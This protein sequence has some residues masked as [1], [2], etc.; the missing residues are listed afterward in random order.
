MRPLLDDILSQS[1]REQ[2]DKN[3]RLAVDKIG[4]FIRMFS[5]GEKKN[6][7]LESFAEYVRKAADS[8]Q[9]KCVYDL[10]DMAYHQCLL[11]VNHQ[12]ADVRGRY[13]ADKSALV[14]AKKRVDEIEN[15]LSVDIDD[16][17]VQKLYKTIA[18][19]N[20]QIEE[21]GIRI[22]NLKKTDPRQTVNSSEPL[23]SSIAV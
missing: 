4:E 17:K 16:K 21:I 5:K 15:Y 7:A 18:Q 20:V 3:T 19:L 8:Q 22:E 12:L 13:E 2:E 14:S 23:P 1:R 10:S 9:T 11:L 6:K